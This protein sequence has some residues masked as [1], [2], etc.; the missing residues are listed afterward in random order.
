MA[1]SVK[2]AN[3]IKQ[4]CNQF[5]KQENIIQTFCSNLSY[6]AFAIL[7]CCPY[8]QMT[9]AIF[10]HVADITLCCFQVFLD[11]L[12]NFSL[13]CFSNISRTAFAVFK[14]IEYIILKQL[15]PFLTFC[16]YHLQA[17]LPF[18]NMFLKSFL[19][20]L[21][22]FQTGLSNPPQAVIATFKHV[23][24]AVFIILKHVAHISFSDSLSILKFVADSPIILRQPVPFLC[25]QLR[26]S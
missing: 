5:L 13:C 18:S 4:A 25:P 21:R 6:A 7:T 26:R 14:H 3:C 23:A 15:L 22:H 10:K 11:R 24:Q 20:N 8:S 2:Q 19:G 12:C 9:F 17:A 1:A 16:L